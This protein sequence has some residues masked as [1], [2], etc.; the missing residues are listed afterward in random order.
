MYLDSRIRDFVSRGVRA[1]WVLG[2][3]DGCHAAGRDR[4]GSLVGCVSHCPEQDRTSP[5]IAN[6]ERPRGRWIVWRR[7]REIPRRILAQPKLRTAGKDRHRVEPRELCVH[8]CGVGSARRRGGKSK[9]ENEFFCC[10]PLDNR[11]PIIDTA[12]GPER[13]HRESRAEL[14]I[15]PACARIPASSPA[16]A[17]IQRNSPAGARIQRNSPGIATT[18]A[19][20]SKNDKGCHEY[21]FHRRSSARRLRRCV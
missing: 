3:A 5:S 20:N 21:L 8:G 19:A 12:P 15:R 6:R 9:G 2:D 4:H 16:S 1:K 7:D 14:F 10:A 18:G 17:R 13:I 11:W